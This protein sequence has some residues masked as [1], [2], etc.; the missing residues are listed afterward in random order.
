MLNKVR[1]LACYGDVI[2]MR[3][4]APG[5]AQTAR[6]VSSIPVINAGDGTGEHPTQALLD[7]YT[8]REELGTVN[9]LTITIVGDLLHGRTAHSLVKLLTLYS[10]KIN[11]VSPSILAMPK[12]IREFVSQFGITQYE[13]SD[14]AKVISETDVLY[15]TRIQKE[16]FS[17][18]EDYDKVKDA[19]KITN[20]VL[21]SAKEHMI[22]KF[23][24][25]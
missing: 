12:D 9:G 8:I 13:T 11:Y 25:N 23:Q 17:T 7:V 4:P 19:Y 10:V 21:K 22:G 14:L 20:A 24:L 5:S 15:V 18:K 3:H 6:E 1:T 2:V 16:R